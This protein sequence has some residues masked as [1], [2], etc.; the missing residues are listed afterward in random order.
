MAPLII[1]CIYQYLCQDLRDFSL[2]VRLRVGG[3]DRVLNNLL[4]VSG[5]KCFRVSRK[6]RRNYSMDENVHSTEKYLKG[7]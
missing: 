3:V 4:K 5:K 1:P 2:Q 7:F 6:I